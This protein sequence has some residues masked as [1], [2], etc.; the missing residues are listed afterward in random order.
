[1]FVD[2]IEDRDN[3]GFDLPVVGVEQAIDEMD[4][5]EWAS[6]EEIGM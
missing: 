4:Q 1:M 3:A 5:A 2:E 6:D